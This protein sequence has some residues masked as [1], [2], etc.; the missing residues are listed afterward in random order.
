MRSP[1]SGMRPQPPPKMADKAPV[2]LSPS[3]N[4]A[5]TEDPGPM[6]T[7]ADLQELY[8]DLVP[9]GSFI[10][11]CP[12]V[13]SQ[14]T[15]MGIQKPD[16]VIEEEQQDA[17][18]RGAVIVAISEKVRINKDNLFDSNIVVGNR[19]HTHLGVGRPANFF[20]R[21]FGGH[22]VRVLVVDVNT[23]VTIAPASE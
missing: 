5:R 22:D 23:I 3:G 12:E 14:F 15:P 16:G 4:E 1:S 11:I 10:H 7:L 9:T 18:D 13:V 20:N 21:K 8:S 19:A 6:P 17:A 2:I